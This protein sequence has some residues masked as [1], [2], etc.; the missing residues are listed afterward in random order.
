MPLRIRV[1]DTSFSETSLT[2]NGRNYYIR[3]RYHGGFT[4][5]NWVMDIFDSNRNNL[6]VGKRIQ[7]SVNLTRHNLDLE[8]LLNGWLFCVN[9]GGRRVDIDRDNLG[10]D[11]NF[12]I[13]YVSKD[14]IDATTQT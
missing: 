10:N 1:E 11:K 3:F 5:A 14:E 13:W 9:V 2:L 4:K 6:L 7:P 8:E 12:E